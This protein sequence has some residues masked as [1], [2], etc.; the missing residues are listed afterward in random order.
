MFTGALVHGCGCV[1]VTWLMEF[2]AIKYRS[3]VTAFAYV[4]FDIGI[5]KVLYY[6][7]RTFIL[8][9]LKVYEFTIYPGV[10]SEPKV[11]K[12]VPGRITFRQVAG[13]SF[14]AMFVAFCRS[15]CFNCNARVYH[16]PLRVS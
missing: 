8:P 4:M 6:C 1:T 2:V 5:A 11:S 13:A 7:P 12:L 15:R 9:K 14:I 3:W 16:V 10:T